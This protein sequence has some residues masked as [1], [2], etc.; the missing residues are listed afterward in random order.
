MWT[1]GEFDLDVE[2]SWDSV[3]KNF[4]DLGIEIILYA[5]TKLCYIEM[6]ILVTF[7]IK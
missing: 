5:A 3:K 4:I 6:L 7:I 1:E 2:E